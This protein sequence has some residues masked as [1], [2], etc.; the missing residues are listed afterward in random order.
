M[1]KYLVLLIALA[2]CKTPQLD[3]ASLSA[4]DGQALAG[5]NLTLVGNVPGRYIQGANAAYVLAK[6]VVKD[7][8]IESVKAVTRQDVES[9]RGE[10]SVILQSAT[11]AE[12]DVIYPGMINLHNH[13][14]QNSL[15]VWA[16]AKGQFANRFEWRDWGNYTKAVSFNMNPWIEHSSTTCASFRWSE[17]QAMVIGTTHLQGPSSCISNYAIHQVEDSMAYNEDSNV[18]LLDV[19]A[20][21]DLVVP[22]DMPFVWRQLKPLID[23]GKTYE[24]ALLIKLKEFCPRLISTFNI[25]NVFDPDAV[26]VFKEKE[27]VEANCDQVPDKLVR[28]V[29]WQHKNIAGKRKYL[30]DPKRAGLIFHLAEGR[31]KDP[32]NLVEFEMIKLFG[33]DLPGANLVHAVGVDPKNYPHMAA[34]QMGIIWSPFSNMLLYGETL[35]VK[36]AMQA[37]VLLALG[38]DWTPTGSRGVLEEL[39]IARAYVQKMGLAGLVTDE[40]LYEMATENPAKMLNHFETKAGDGRHE[41]GRVVVD[42]AA[43]LVVMSRRSANP[44]TNLVTGTAAD[45]NLVV[46]DGRPVYGEQK[47][48]KQWD[49]NA[50]LDPLPGSYADTSAALLALQTRPFPADGT[51]DEQAAALAA[52]AKE[53]KVAASGPAAS[54]CASTKRMIRHVT[55][56]DAVVAFKGVSGLDLDLPA[57]IGKLLAIGLVGQSHNRNPIS[58]KGDSNFAA[59]VLPPMFACDDPDYEA[60]VAK[61]VVPEAEGNDEFTQ[62]AAGRKDRRKQQ[63]MLNGPKKLAESYGQPYDT[64]VDY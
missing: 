62:N 4:A 7:G 42:A 58:G 34:R 30:Q 50:T 26:A 8:V 19:Q 36:A 31:R 10:G 2:S 12:F 55:D 54:K 5:G 32:Y 27:K 15:Q 47:Y 39:R 44:Y 38:S 56:E 18:R 6:V 57:D 40:K 61:F 45:V 21:T 64:A 1:L 9:L 25:T 35:D 60:R 63:N 33:L 43:S 20:P 16:E 28:F 3:Q 17:L 11:G 23:G 46:I 13:T 22:E 14:K 37:G 48:L 49:A 51:K 52:L 29:Y 59:K 41:L 24:E 53:S